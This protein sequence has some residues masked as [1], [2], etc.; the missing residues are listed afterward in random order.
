MRRRGPRSSKARALLAGL[1]ALAG[2]SPAPAPATPAE[3]T[4]TPTT[5]AASEWHSCAQVRDGTLRCWGLDPLDDGSGALAVRGW[6][7]RVG[8][9]VPG[10]GPVRD[11]DLGLRHGCAAL[12]TGALHC[13]GRLDGELFDAP[14]VPS[15]VQAMPGP[16]DVVDVAVGSRHGCA[17]TRAG[18]LWCWGANENGQLGDGTDKTRATP[19]DTKLTAIAAVA[20]NNHQ[21]CA[22]HRDGGVSCW[23]DLSDAAGRL[24]RARPFAVRWITDAVELSIGGRSCIRH[25]DG[26]VECWSWNPIEREPFTR[27][28]EILGLTAPIRISAGGDRGCALEADGAVKCWTWGPTDSSDPRPAYPVP[29]VRG[30]VEVAVGDRHACARI[31]APDA[32]EGSIRCWGNNEHGQLGDGLPRLAERPLRVA[33]LGDIVEVSAGKARTCARRRDGALRCW[34]ETIVR[35]LQS[36]IRAV[37]QG[38]SGT[39]TEVATAGAVEEIDATTTG[40]CT[41]SGTRVVCF[42]S[43]DPQEVL[44]GVRAVDLP[45]NPRFKCWVTL[46]GRVSCSGSPGWQRCDGDADECRAPREVEGAADI[47][48][49]AVGQN[50]GC[51]LDERGAVWCW[52][53]LDGQWPAK[54][55]TR[56]DAIDPAIGVATGSRHTC[57][58]SAGGALW[59]WGAN[60]H[61]EAGGGTTD[62]RA[63]P[64]R[65]ALASPCVAA[66]GGDGFTCAALADGR[67]QCWGVNATGQLGDGTRATRSLPGDV[68]GL[69]GVDA[70]SSG[71][72]HTCARTRA[73]EVWCWGAGFA[74]QLGQ[75]TEP[76]LAAPVRVAGLE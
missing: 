27:P 64:T 13:W 21:T 10:L 76:E 37:E 16:V 36:P 54:P 40:V 34:G 45:P 30:A 5:L 20:A 63:A 71:L 68:V 46:A 22:L 72:E 4:A 3:R 49:L 56:V 28:F 41:R 24:A 51:G 15:R 62:P 57:A 55:A 6:E 44:E 31:G 67:V 19:V 52:G 14:P 47:V 66:A 39:P 17:V 50:H 65:V 59:C 43:D 60:D 61:G 9:V 25:A 2:C 7:P 48:Q 12:A 70:L 58:W 74:G 11:L 33:G 29:D 8:A 23:G 53:L 73:G 75:G 32:A 26:K 18:G 1:A 42:D 35:T 38:W 69:T